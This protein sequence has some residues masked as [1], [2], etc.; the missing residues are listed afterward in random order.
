[1]VPY[2]KELLL[3]YP[4]VFTAGTFSHSGPSQEQLDHTTFKITFFAAGFADTASREKG[5]SIIPQS[6]LCW[7]LLTTAGVLNKRV[8]VTVA[9]PE[10]GYVAT[11]IMFVTLA[12]CLL[13]EE[14][15]MPRGV[16]TPGV[17]FYDSA[18]I[19]DRLSAAGV[20]FTAEES[21][22]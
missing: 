5:T 10:P 12:R 9:G 16:L 4:G 15:N 7:K 19:V 17:A 6:S 11:S 22:A 2:G 20:K 18:T 13:E 8:T 21:S 1:M 3:S 14:A